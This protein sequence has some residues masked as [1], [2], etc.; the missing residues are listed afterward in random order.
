MIS[1]VIPAYNEEKLIH[2]CLS[3]FINQDTKERFEVI[4]VDNASTD[5][6][7]E[8]ASHFLDRI[9]LRI[10]NEKRKG[11][12][13]ARF[14]GFSQARGEVILSTDADCV[15]PP[16]WISS[17]FKE[18]EKGKNS[19]VTGSCY[20]NDLS[21]FK[22]WLFNVS[23]PAAMRIYR[24]L[25]GHYWLNG[26]NFGIYRDKYLMSGGFDPNLNAQEDIDL[27]FKVYKL[28]KIVYAPRV[29]LLFSGRRFSGGLLSGFKPYLMTFI[30]FYWRKKND[31][32][33]EDKR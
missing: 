18:L 7:Y 16:D 21:P 11:R 10:I 17:L 22:N 32:Y 12:G 27:S 3:A 6:T 25:F 1:V 23:Q 30:N 29:S 4:L 15:V 14:S 31:I 20:V 19:A 24:F 2:R 5:K 8:I 33:L 28:G 26:F 9:P 13:S